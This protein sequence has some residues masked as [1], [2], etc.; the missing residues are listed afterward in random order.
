MN[1]L[2]FTRFFKWNLHWIICGLLSPWETPP[3]NQLKLIILLVNA[4][5]KAKKYIFN[6][7]SIYKRTSH[8]DTVRSWAVLQQQQQ[9]P[10]ATMWWLILG[11][12][13]S[14]SWLLLMLLLLLLLLGL[15]FVPDDAFST[16]WSPWP[17]CSPSST[18]WNNWRNEI[19]VK[20]ISAA[21][22]SCFGLLL[23]S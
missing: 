1:N 19:K 17:S 21:P 6:H 7:N 11:P 18:C 23:L 2:A 14:S 13:V 4:Y 5:I 10:T 20:A 3:R 15:P 9:L 16:R 22:S 8:L 12:R